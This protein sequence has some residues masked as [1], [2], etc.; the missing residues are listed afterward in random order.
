MHRLA[1]GHALVHAGVCTDLLRPDWRGA[2]AWCDDRAIDRRTLALAALAAAVAALVVLGASEARARPDLAPGGGGALALAVQLAAGV[3][4]VAAAVH[5]ARRRE[6]VLAVALLA[7]AAGLGLHALPSPPASAALFALV[8]VAAGLAP[9]AAAHVALLYPEGR[10]A[11]RLD[12]A[13]VVIGYGVHVGLLGLLPALVLDPQATGCFDCP[14]NVLLA[15][16]D[17]G[18]Y[19]WLARWG[20]R[21]AAAVDAGLV[22]LVLM[23]LVRRPVAARALALPVSAAAI[24]ALVLSAIA[25]IRAANG[26]A[27]DHGVWLAT[28]AALGVLAAGIAWRPLR[29]ARVRRALARLTVAGP[30]TAED[31][32]GAL[33]R[34]LGDPGVTLVIPHPET[35]RPIDADGASAP[36]AAPVG[37]ARIAVERR[38]RVVAWVE[39]RAIPHSAPELPAAAGLVVEREALRVAQRLQ[40]VDLRASTERLVAAGDAERRRLERDLHDGAQQRLLALGLGLARARTAAPPDDVATLAEVETGVSTLRDELRRVAHGIHSVTLVEGGLAE[41]ILALVQAAPS[42]VTVVAL[43]ERRA[44]AQAE[45]AIY[46]LVAASLRVERQTGVRIAIR[47]LGG[48]LDASVLV[49]GVGPATLSDALSHAGARVS[50]LGGSLAVAS[51]SGGSVA[52][53]RVPGVP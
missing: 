44:S 20:P 47:T 17:A 46:R 39:H 51:E 22:L 25:Y 49:H 15:H 3:A 6:R 12:R 27:V 19:E 24:A 26:L 7:A 37:R 30:A 50:A 23:R 10:L 33:A 16:A 11:G 36:V 48:E 21:V 52:H 40:E 4:L 1:W 38:G 8:L 9:A 45:A 14:D 18:A 43:P 13:A 2:T 32:R 41:A 34:A 42:G 5:A 28:V 29:A 53:A 35:G 31:V